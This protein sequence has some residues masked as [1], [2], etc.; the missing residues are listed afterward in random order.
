VGSS[1]GAKKAVDRARQEEMKR[2]GLSQ[3]M[4]D[5][6]EEVGLA[7][8]QC[9]QGLTQVQASLETQQRLARRLDADATALYEKA[10][11][12]MA[13]NQETKAR[14]YLFERQKVQDRLKEVLENCVTAKKQVATMEKNAAVLEQR[15]M[16]IETL[17]QRTV[18][19]TAMQNTESLG[20]SLSQSDPLLQKFKDLGIE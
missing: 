20:L 1:L 14:E 10:K 12:A 3:D 8:E 17:L 13:E 4:L 18:G 9:M 2:L 19:A 7:L 16:E 5:S 6:A 15:A 11:D